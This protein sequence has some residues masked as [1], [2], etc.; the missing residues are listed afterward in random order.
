L[1]GRIVI[2]GAA[3]WDASAGRA[4]ESSGMLYALAMEV[5][6]PGFQHALSESGREALLALPLASAT[7]GVAQPASLRVTSAAQPIALSAD[8]RHV[9][10]VVA[11]GEV[12][13]WDTRRGQESRREAVAQTG[14]SGV[15][16]Q[17][18]RAAAGDHVRGG[19]RY[20]SEP[21]PR[22]RQCHHGSV[23]LGTE[24]GQVDDL[25]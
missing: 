1:F 13:I 7:F 5:R 22:H 8:S 16:A 10:G 17:S 9:A 21:T 4:M 19:A 11:P 20:P 25:Q 24:L 3:M 23:H 2:L 18:R 15:W 14:V 12:A 6:E